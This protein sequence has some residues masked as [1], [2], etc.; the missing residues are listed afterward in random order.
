MTFRIFLIIAQFE[1]TPSIPSRCIAGLEDPLLEGSGDRL[2][3]SPEKVTKLSHVVRQAG[4]RRRACPRI[5]RQDPGRRSRQ[6]PPTR[7]LAG[8]SGWI[9]GRAREAKDDI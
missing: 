1:R 3:D 4:A 9:R 2:R 8:R 7:N 5:K 6:R